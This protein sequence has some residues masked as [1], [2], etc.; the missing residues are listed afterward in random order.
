MATQVAIPL[1][2][3]LSKDFH[4]RAAV[5][6]NEDDTLHNWRQNAFEKFRQ[7]G[8]P[9][10]RQED[11]K[12]TNLVPYLKE[13]LQT[14]PL[15]YDYN[16]ISPEQASQ[17]HLNKLDA[18]ILVLV[19]G[20]LNTSLSS[21]HGDADVS[22]QSINSAASHQHYRPYL[23][24]EIDLKQDTLAALNSALFSD[25]LFIEVRGNAVVEKPLHVI[26]LYTSAG[27][28]FLQPRNLIVA[29]K[30]C[31]VSII[32]TS[33]NI[34]NGS[35]VWVN[36]V[37]EVYAEE[38]AQVNH[39]VLQSGLTNTRQVNH[40]EV[41]QKTR[42]LYNNYTVTLPDADLVRNNLNINL[43]ESGT[44]THLYGLYLAAEQQLVD[45][46]TTVDHR[47][48]NCFS[49]ELYK[50]VLTGNAKAVFNGKIFVHQEAQKTNAFQQ[51]NNLLLSDRAVIDSKPQLEIFADDVKCSHGSTAGQF[52]EEALFYL[53]SRGIGESSA[54]SL[55]VSAFAFDVINKIKIGA[56]RSH[57]EKLIS[58]NL[59]KWYA[60]K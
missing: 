1:Y 32:E 25:G 7:Q 20:K 46:H 30:S 5:P 28:I 12:Y 19:N 3:Q 8:F 53:R 21:F 39:Y 24:K 16:E 35:I 43:V 49:N 34:S 13:D 56:L 58:H 38:N 57:I 31:A 33:A 23:G 27:N 10:I 22:V 17:F 55:M 40:T 18:N 6:E 51:N 48:P 36:S 45:N 11:W 26:N 54:R 2:D 41:T 44:E 9:S 29:H 50:G 52:N 37:T 14:E 4:Q 15:A 42:S 60:S 47:K 59:S